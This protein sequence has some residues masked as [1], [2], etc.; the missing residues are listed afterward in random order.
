MTIARRS[1]ARGIGMAVVALTVVAWP[2]LA[3]PQRPADAPGGVGIDAVAGTTIQRLP[4]CEATIRTRVSEWK[5]HAAISCKK[6]GAT[7]EA[8]CN[9]AK[10]GPRAEQLKR[11]RSCKFF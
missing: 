8:T 9:Q 11:L 6:S 1:P 2:A 5:A 10:L 7:D 4:M 3:A